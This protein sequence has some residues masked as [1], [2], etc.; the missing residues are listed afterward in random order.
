MFGLATTGGIVPTTGVAGLT[1]GGGWGWLARSFGLA[2]D[3]LLSVDVVTAEGEVLV[4][5][6]LEHSELF[7]GIRGGGGNFGIATSFEFR[8][9]RVGALVAG[10]LAFPLENARAVLRTYAELTRSAPDALAAYAALTVLPDGQRVIGIRV[11]YNGSVDQARQS[12]RALTDLR[13]IL[14]SVGPTT[15]GEVQSAGEVRYPPGLFHYWKANF[16]TILSDAAIETLLAHFGML[17]SRKSHIVIEQ[18]GGAVARTGAIATAFAH[19]NAGYS[20][21]LLGVAEDRAE[22][23][24]AIPWIRR[25]WDAMRPF[26]ASGVYV[27]Y[28]GSEADEGVE[29]IKAAYQ[30]GTYER[31][32]A[33]KRKHDPD[34][35]FRV[36]QNI[37]P[38]D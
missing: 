28:L 6:D 31:L 5:N 34:N 3:N 8:L 38:A 22:F 4:S 19:R 29:R 21:L 24:A 27:N 32:A 30:P 20:L 13:P 36:N 9:H 2:C 12:L 35:F 37:K 17:P 23:E 11:C 25:L 26:C 15:Y 7:W 14:D 10:L 33:L 16:L 1:L 18:L